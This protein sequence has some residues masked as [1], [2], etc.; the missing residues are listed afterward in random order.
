MSR[1]PECDYDIVVAGGGA[2]GVGAAL[3]AAL[4]GADVLL[5]EKY[6]FLGGAATTSNVLAYCGFFQQGETP[7]KAVEWCRR[8]RT[9]RAAQF[10]AG[11]QSV[12]LPDNA[13][14]DYPFG[15]RSGEAGIGPR[16]DQ[17]GR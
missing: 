1:K 4:E 17:G 8:P 16:V 11:L 2:G 5:V 9:R 3:G 10:E 6:G 7:I 15:T 13:K 12:L 14:L